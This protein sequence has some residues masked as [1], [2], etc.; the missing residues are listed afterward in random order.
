MFTPP[1][2]G[3]DVHDTTRWPSALPEVELIP[4]RRTRLEVIRDVLVC[5]ACLCVVSGIAAFIYA[6][7]AL[8][9]TLAE[10]GACT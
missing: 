3:D 1:R 8:G 4:T 6:V 2:R 10:T 9:R 7:L 5:L